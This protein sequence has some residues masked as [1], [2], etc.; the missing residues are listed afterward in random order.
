MNIK[1]LTVTELNRQVR[2][3][4]ENDVGQIAVEGEIS[5]L[6][7]PSSG[8]MYFT[9]KDQMSQIRA[10]FF[11]SR[12]SFNPDVKLENGNQIIAYG[13][14]SL[15]ETRGDFQ[16]II[17][18]I[19]AAGIGNLFK[20]FME[21]KEKLQGLGLFAPEKKRPIPKF[22][23]TIGIITSPK[24]AA[25]HDMLTTL[26]AR[27]PLAK[28]LIYESEVQGATAHLQIINAL[29]RANNDNRANVILL[30][31]G[32]GSIED[33]WAFNEESLAYEIANSKI[34]I[35][36]GVG[37]ETDF[38]IA[39]FVAD[40]RAP[41][42]TAAAQ[43]VT[44]DAFELLIMLKGI[45]ETLLRATVRILS[46]KKMK[47]EHARK[48]LSSP[49]YIIFKHWQALDYLKIQLGKCMHYQL[50][51]KQ[52]NLAITKASLMQ[53]SPAIK[54]IQAKHKLINLKR[55]LVQN[56]ENRLLNLKIFLKTKQTTLDLVSPLQTLNRG[57][58]IVKFKNEILVDAN[59]VQINDIIDIELKSGKLKSKVIE[60][61]NAS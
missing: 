5:N 20:K 50:S 38:T 61:I 8:H 14:P 35:V 28:V 30:A 7:K 57:Y 23:E 25:V 32:G 29:R 40:H 46:Y 6:S 52:H 33:L 51:H 1:T 53:Q 13:K 58:A 49:K 55:R 39:D 54:L 2:L 3:I 17:D 34:P 24:G 43:K 15:Y 37:H 11:K 18:K 48:K 45:V 16:L 9:L 26:K 19:E 47:L 60:K 21:L 10:V 4:L 42:P 41:T 56:M 59:N 44:P 12:N 27:Y 36:S 22:P 31:R